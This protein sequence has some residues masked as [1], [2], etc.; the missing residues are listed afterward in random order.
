M[1]AISRTVI[2]LAIV[3]VSTSMVS[4]FTRTNIEIS[5]RLGPNLKIYDMTTIRSKRRHC[6][7][8]HQDTT[9]SETELF[10]NSTQESFILKY[11]MTAA[12][13]LATKSTSRGCEQQISNLPTN[14]F[15]LLTWQAI[16]ARPRPAFT[17]S[18]APAEPPSGNKP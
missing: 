16:L 5:L 11:V 8:H 6:Y 7:I 2:S 4:H 9:S 17:M 14:T 3:L 18:G 1:H 10:A 13:A 15:P 12:Q